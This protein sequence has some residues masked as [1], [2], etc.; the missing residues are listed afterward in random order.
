MRQNVVITTCAAL[1]NDVS[2]NEQ[3]HLLDKSVNNIHE[4]LG[5]M[6]SNNLHVCM[7]PSVDE[8]V[9]KLRTSFYGIHLAKDTSAN[10]FY[11]IT[12][13]VA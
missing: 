1:L 2:M 8:A 12:G 5:I 13:H 6:C 9:N 4:H 11:G 10:R 3:T 7:F